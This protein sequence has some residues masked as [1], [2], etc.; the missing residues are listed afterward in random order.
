MPDWSPDGRWI[1]YTADDG[2]T[3]IQLEILNVETGETR[4]LT[5]DS[6]IY[7]DPVF[8]PDGSRVA[9]VSTRPNGFFNVYIRPIKDGQWAGDEIAVTRDNKYRELAPLL[10]R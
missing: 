10:W 4:A 2:G 5:N 3:T 6:F 7:T 8:S 9:Y 1:I